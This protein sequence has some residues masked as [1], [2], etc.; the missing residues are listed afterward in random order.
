MECKVWMCVGALQYMGFA[1]FTGTPI[2]YQR[3]VRV[4][5]NLPVCYGKDQNLP[6][7]SLIV[8][9]MQLHRMND[10]RL[11]ALRGVKQRRY[12]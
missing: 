10:H 12:S 6:Y 8:T 2:A 3:E 5:E 1:H 11:T 4:C 7:R 9:P